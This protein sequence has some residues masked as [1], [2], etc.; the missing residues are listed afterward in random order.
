MILAN[1]NSNLCWNT[2]E[3]SLIIIGNTNSAVA[4]EVR[5]ASKS[6]T[7]ACRMLLGNLNSHAYVR[8]KSMKYR[9]EKSICFRVIGSK[10]NTV[11]S[12]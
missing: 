12:K 10:A 9:A 7:I 6:R 8:T 2:V 4:F 5:I 11:S 3:V 1:L